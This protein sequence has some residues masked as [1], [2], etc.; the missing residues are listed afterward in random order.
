[1][2][3]SVPPIL[4]KSALLCATMS[5]PA[6][7]GCVSWT[8]LRY[9]EVRSFV[10]DLPADTSVHL[11]TPYG[12]VD[13]AGRDSSPPS[14]IGPDDQPDATQTPPNHTII[15]AR[16]RSSDESRLAQ[17]VIAPVLLDGRLTIDPTLPPK[18]GKSKDAIDFV[19]LAGRQPGAIDIDTGYGDVSVVT[20]HASAAIDTG[21]GDV[22]L[23]DTLGSS[24]INTGYGDV[25]ATHIMGPLKIDSGYGDFRVSLPSNFQGKL[26]LATGY[27][28]ITLV[29]LTVPEG[30]IVLG[31]GYGDVTLNDHLGASG[32]AISRSKGAAAIAGDSNFPAWSV[33]TGYGDID[34]RITSP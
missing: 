17:I 24:T 13:V 27:G 34:A 9:E 32:R 7:S 18:V 8:D 2:L 12:D 6:M 19:I 23:Q 4:A 22:T 3:A 30:P 20:P 21:Y 29:S 11:V 10:L 14:W 33:S 28:D 25:D 31:T 26:G 15:Y 5:V 16:V 1:M